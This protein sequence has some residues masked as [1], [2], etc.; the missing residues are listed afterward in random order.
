MRKKAMLIF[1][2]LVLVMTVGLTAVA[3]GNNDGDKTTTVDKKTIVYLGD[4]IAEALIGPSPLNFRD[5]YGYYAILGR[6]NDYKYYNRSV[7]GHKTKDLLKIVDAKDEDAKMTR[8]L[9]TRADIIHISILGNDMLQEPLGKLL[10]AVNDD[11]ADK[12][13]INNIVDKAVSNIF[14]IISYIKRYNPTATLIFQ[15]VYNPVFGETSLLNDNDIEYGKNLDGTEDK[16][17]VVYPGSK[18]RLGELIKAKYPECTNPVEKYREYA[19]VLLNKLDGVLD[20]C[21]LGDEDRFVAP[22][23][24]I[25]VDAKAEF[26]R[27]YDEDPVRGA[28]L[29]FV[30][31]IHPSNDGHAVLADLTQKTLEKLNLANH[32]SALNNYKNMRINVLTK[33]FNGL[34]AVV[35]SIKAATSCEQVSSIYYQEIFKKG[36]APS[37]IA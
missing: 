1:L 17:N 32:D 5:E 7:S 16:T 26:D 29:L 4:S 19:T 15:N 18:T 20:T 34:P 27:I 21:L 24:F 10:V 22:N 36:I 6:R 28:N 33:H 8:S 9:I 13:P 11:T 30:D 23:S 12:S 31:D 25:I 2:S 14:E 3:C 35:D 37:Y